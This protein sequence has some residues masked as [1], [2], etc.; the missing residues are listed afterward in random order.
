MR[1]RSSELICSCCLMFFI[2]TVN[3]SVRRMNITLVVR[4]CVS[5][6]SRE[7]CFLK[8]LK[9]SQYKNDAIQFQNF[10]ILKLPPFSVTY[11]ME[12]KKR[13]F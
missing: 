10:L 3:P 2:L 6:P 8:V 12:G 9:C 5:E 7:L 1:K 13:Q 4:V 11:M